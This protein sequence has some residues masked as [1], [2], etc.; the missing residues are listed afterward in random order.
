MTRTDA[1]V[2]GRYDRDPSITLLAR[3]A[4]WSPYEILSLALPVAGGAV[5]PAARV[6]LAEG[7]IFV[8]RDRDTLSTGS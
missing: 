1:C 6:A 3:F 4:F 7:S 5:S 8:H 2:S